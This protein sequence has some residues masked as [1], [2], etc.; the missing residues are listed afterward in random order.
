[1]HPVGSYR[2]DMPRC[3]VNKTLKIYLLSACGLKYL[4]HEKRD[5]GVNVC[6]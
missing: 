2:T 6:R 5:D 1:V 3:T 4:G